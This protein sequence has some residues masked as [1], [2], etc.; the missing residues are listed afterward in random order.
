M[1][2]LMTQVIS[3]SHEHVRYEKSDLFQE[4]TNK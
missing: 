4:N 1:Q 3:M 2:D